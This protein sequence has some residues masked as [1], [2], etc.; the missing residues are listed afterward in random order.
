MNSTSNAL[1][2]RN[3]VGVPIPSGSLYGVLMM[4]VNI[5]LPICLLMAGGCKSGGSNDSQPVRPKKTIER[6]IGTPRECTLRNPLVAFAVRTGQLRDES[7][8]ARLTQLDLANV[9]ARIFINERWSIL[10]PPLEIGTDFDDTDPLI[11]EDVAEVRYQ[12]MLEKRGIETPPWRDGDLWA[13]RCFPSLKKLDIYGNGIEDFSEISS[14]VQLEELAIGLRTDTSDFDRGLALRSVGSPDSLHFLRELKHLRELH[15]GNLSL[16]SLDSLP[17]LPE[18]RVLNL[19]S[20]TLRNVN[21]LAQ[22]SRLEHLSLAYN[23]ID[24]I[25]SL[26]D[27]RHLEVLDISNNKIARLKRFFDLRI[28]RLKETFKDQNRESRLLALM[29]LVASTQIDV[30]QNKICDEHVKAQLAL[31]WKRVV[32]LNDQNCQRDESDGPVSR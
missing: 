3:R 30:S 29:E 27:L 8:A 28:T 20:N 1:P 31:V 9:N 22:F 14:L 24:T 19:T 26:A 18:L 6:T 2:L 17:H 7:Q 25:D 4:G 11:S 23:E 10:G 16:S 13:L 5:G 21:R 32:G 12:S 15:L